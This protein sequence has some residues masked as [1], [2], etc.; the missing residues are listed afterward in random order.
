MKSPRPLPK[1]AVKPTRKGYLDKLSGGKH[2]APKW[3]SRYFELAETGHLN[4]YK[5]PDGKVINQ[6]YLRG[7]PVEI[8]DTDPGIIVIKTD[9]REWQLRAASSEEAQTWYYDVSFY[10]T[11]QSS[12]WVIQL[13]TRMADGTTSYKW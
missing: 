3:D 8:S 5:K 6:I 7:C 10:T 11:K 12:W 4:Y 9:E 13:T 2:Q 1:P